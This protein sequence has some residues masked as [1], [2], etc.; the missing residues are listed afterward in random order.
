MAVDK[1]VICMKW[2]RYYSNDYV[3]I[4][5]KSVARNISTPFRFVCLTDNGSGLADG[6][7]ILPLPDMGLS[8]KRMANGGWQKLCMFM[9]ELYDVKGRVLFLDIDII[10]T[11]SLDVFFEGTSPLLI[12]REWRQL[13]HL[14]SFR[15]FVGCN[16][17]VF[18]FDI[19][20]QTQI[21]ENFMADKEMAFNNFRNEQRFL[22]ANARGLEFWR[23]GM[24]LSFKAD[25]MFYPPLSFILP[26]KQLPLNAH[27]VVF[28]GRPLPEEIVQGRNWGRGLRRG[29]DVVGW[30][31]QAWK[32]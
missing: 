30:A 20:T 9:P 26:P 1:T 32:E 16:S 8:S 3:N 14:L 11:G 19:G 10:I 2:G 25:L 4:L 27:I 22:F 7:D 31:K 15:K 17:S 24:C 18:V 21:Y 23:K 5:Y 29:K 13:G 12:I 6:I 28:H